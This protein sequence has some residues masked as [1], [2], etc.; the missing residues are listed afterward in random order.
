MS[1]DFETRLDD[2][3]AG[4]ASSDLA[5]AP[6]VANLIAVARELHILAP[7]P[8]PRLADGRRRFLNEAARAIQPPHI[9][10]RVIARPVRTFGFAAMLVLI[11][12]GALLIA[13]T[14]FFPGAIPGS[15]SLTLT[16]SPTHLTTPTRTTAAPLNLVPFAPTLVTHLTNLPQPKPV[17]TPIATRD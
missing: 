13:Q 3:L 14:S 2:A 7:T 4:S 17:P 6:E 1:C 5:A 15:S 12:V 9:F 11:V 10:Q 8:Q 16:M